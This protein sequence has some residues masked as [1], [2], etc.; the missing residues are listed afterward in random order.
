MN[1]PL[2]TL[3][4]EPWH[5]TLKGYYKKACRCQLC[6]KA[7]SDNRKERREFLLS[8]PVTGHERW[9][10]TTSGYN[11]RRCR[12]ELCKKAG[13][14]YREKRRKFWA[15]LSIT[16]DESWHGT[17]AS[18]SHR[19]CRCQLCRKAMTISLTVRKYNLSKNFVEEILTD[20]VCSACGKTELEEKKFNFDHDHKCCPGEKSCGKCFRGLL[21]QPCNL[22]L[23]HVKDDPTIL[24]N[25][26]NYLERYSA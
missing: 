11:L 15:N 12:C 22:V 16:G 13:S 23:G 17:E 24:T 5:G 1:E 2:P 4:D 25:L 9:H 6:K 10:G 19:A 7:A 14:D 20:P 3:F 26:V 21:C 8:Q 18:Y